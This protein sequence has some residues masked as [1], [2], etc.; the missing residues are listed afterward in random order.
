MRRFVPFFVALLALFAGA[1]GPAAAYQDLMPYQWALQQI[2]AAAG[3]QASTGA[4]ITVGVVDT[5]ADAGH[6]DFGGRVSTVD[7][8]GGSCRAGGD[9][10]NGHGTHVTG[11][12]AAA[13]DGSG[14]TGVAPNVQVIVAK[15]F[16]CENSSCDNPGASLDDINA[17][18]SYLLSRG[19]AAIN[20]SL[21]D[22]GTFGTGFFCDDST[23]SDLS[24]RIWNAGSVGVFAAGNCGGGLLGGQ[25]L[26]GANALIV[27]ATGGHDE[28]AAYNSSMSGAKWGLAAP[29]GNP[30]GSACRSDGTDCI[31]STWPRSRHESNTASGPYWL[32][33]GT[34]MAAPHVT[35]AVGALRA[36][37]LTRDA[38]VNTIMGSLD[39]ISCGSGC[40]GR[41][42]LQ[43][44]LGAA[45]L[46]TSTTA[47][48]SGGQTF[49]GGSA[50]TTR[51]TRKPTPKPVITA[52]PTTLPP[53]TTT[54][55]M[56]TTTT[57]APIR[58]QALAPVKKDDSSGP[59]AVPVLVAIAGLLAAAGGTGAAAWRR[60]RAA[61]RP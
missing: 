53:A 51:T 10:Q 19:V 54:T 18:V 34:S 48:P 41:L 37:G 11:I 27:G 9:D 16:V 28:P 43:H 61:A 31:L 50:P 14:I 29:G 58:P 4:G 6:P 45:P 3:W 47:P 44:A 15:V 23:F 55:E 1:A 42:N 35:A 30:S 56:V 7:C 36:K 33:A 12:I 17:G 32:E 24:Q 5:G 57:E 46:T 52:A 8:T 39:H 13:N 25:A 21:G 59:G 2:S 20:L 26:S 40:Q 22:P 60:S 49:G 38:A